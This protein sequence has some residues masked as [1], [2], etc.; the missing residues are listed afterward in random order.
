MSGSPVSRAPSLPSLN[1]LNDSLNKTGVRYRIRANDQTPR[2]QIR[3]IDRFEDGTQVRSVELYHAKPGDLE[4]A[5]DLCLQ[6]EQADNPLSVLLHAAP[7]SGN[8]STGWDALVRCLQRHLDKKG[9]KWQDQCQATHMRQ[10]LQFTGPVSAKK[11]MNW[12]E[13]AAPRTSDRV[14][15]LSTL[16][17]LIIC[18]EIDI[19]DN[20]M[21][22]IKDETNFSIVT[23]AINPRDLPEDDQIEAF[24]D[25]IAY[26][27]WRVAFGY[28]ATYGLRPHEIFCI[29]DFSKEDGLLEINSKKIKTGQE[30]WRFVPA[31]RVDWIERWNLSSGIQ[32]SHDLQHTAKRLGHR[33]SIQFARYRRK[34]EV[35]VWRETAK[36][37]DLRHAY[38]AAIHTQS[39]FEKISIDQAA[40]WMGHSRKVHVQNYLR[41]LSK[42]SAKEA[43]RR[44]AA[45]LG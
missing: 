41:W 23:K 35:S 14:R 15:R 38:A 12:V 16:N 25:S 21:A 37:Y 3:A 4:K 8:L 28:I 17:K 39:K 18:A 19:P 45:A 36:T 2:I 11:L 44:I 13:A 33:V 30:G 10:F 34:E 29:T 40:E 9:L 7:V 5:R 1:E 24:V 6:L 20:W 26:E 32:I 43:A 31:R 27:P 42:S 22:R